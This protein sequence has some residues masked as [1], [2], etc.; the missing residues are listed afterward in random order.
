M[1]PDGDMDSL[2]EN[3]IK[4]SSEQDSL[5]IQQTTSDITATQTKEHKQ[6]NSEPTKAHED[7]FINKSKDV[8]SE[9]AENKKQNLENKSEN[10]SN[11]QNLHSTRKGKTEHDNKILGNTRSQEYLTGDKTYCK[12][13]NVLSIYTSITSNT[14]IKSQSAMS[15]LIHNHTECNTSDPIDKTKYNSDNPK[16]SEVSCV[17]K[18]NVTSKYGLFFND[19]NHKDELSEFCSQTDD[20]TE[21]CITKSCD[22]VPDIVQRLNNE[23]NEQ[24]SNEFEE[25]DVTFEMLC[26]V[27]GMKKIIGFT[28]TEI[29]ALKYGV[30]SCSGEVLGYFEQSLTFS[31]W[32]NEIQHEEP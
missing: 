22:K 10:L 20:E 12:T 30:L 29:F 6:S 7:N 15:Q 21:K 4:T 19:E 17:P 13:D 31:F 27:F 11:T 5:E 28:P 32:Q 3:S 23:E 9:F 16:N 18:E 26:T 25:N 24:L 8:R 2:I 14:S 1:N